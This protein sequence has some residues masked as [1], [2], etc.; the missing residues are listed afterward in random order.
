MDDDFKYAIPA[1]GLGDTDLDAVARTHPDAAKQIA[2]LAERMAFGKDTPEEFCTLCQLLHDVGEP[3]NAEYLLRRNLD[4]GHP[5]HELYLKLFGMEKPNKFKSAI[6]SFETQFEIA[7][8]LV[9][10][11]DFLEATY[12]TDG[13]PSRIGAFALLAEPC[14]VRFAYARRAEIECGVTN[15]DSRRDTLEGAERLL[16]LFTN[17]VWEIA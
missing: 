16:L 9:E 5:S 6:E 10:E 7:L 11:A 17:G 12:R 3:G 13:G 15:Q 8:E 4:V 14:A 2:R 1:A